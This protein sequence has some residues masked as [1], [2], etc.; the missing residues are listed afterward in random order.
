[1]HVRAIVKTNQKVITY[2]AFSCHLQM[3]HMFYN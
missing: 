2:S 3:L 1:M